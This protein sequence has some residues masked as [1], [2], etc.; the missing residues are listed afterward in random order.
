MIL[1]GH[2]TLAPRLGARTYA[3][4]WQDLRTSPTASTGEQRLTPANRRG[5]DVA[6][7]EFAPEG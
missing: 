3:A 7:A 1:R 4:A 2:A 6:N 5:G